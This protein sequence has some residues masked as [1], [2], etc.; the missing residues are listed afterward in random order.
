MQQQKTLSINLVFLLNCLS[1]FAI[2]KTE[3]NLKLFGLNFCKR[4]VEM[5]FFNL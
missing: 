5:L 4:L 3:I 2:E 1:F